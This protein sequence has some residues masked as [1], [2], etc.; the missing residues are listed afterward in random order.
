MCATGS[1]MF[2]CIGVRSRRL[3]GRRSRGERIGFDSGRR[4]GAGFGPRMRPPGSMRPNLAESVSGRYLSFR[5]RGVPLCV[6]TRCP[7]RVRM[8][9][10]TPR[11]LGEIVGQVGSKFLHV[12]RAPRHRERPRDVHVVQAPGVVVEPKHERP[13]DGARLVPSRVE[14]LRD[15]AVE[16][17]PFDSLEPLSRH[18]GV[19]RRGRHVDRLPVAVE[20]LF[21]PGAPLGERPI[22]E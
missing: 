16:P 6:P 1:V 4:S 10:G 12:F 13:H 7:A 22:D 8:C 20:R 15:D 14:R 3:G 17:G 2:V 18:E 21:Q 19:A 9:P 5:E 11:V